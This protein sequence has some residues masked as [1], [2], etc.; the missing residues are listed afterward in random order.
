M[1]ARRNARGAFSNANTLNFVA[2]QR[3]AA[4]RSLPASIRTSPSAGRTTRPLRAAREA[5]STSASIFDLTR[6]AATQGLINSSSTSATIVDAGK[7]SSRRRPEQQRP[8]AALVASV[9]RAAAGTVMLAG[10][11]TYR[12]T[13][14]FSAV[15]GIDING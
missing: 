4:R 15:A 9:L 14:P 12:S 1:S 5:A 6:L 3:C 7:S 13:M 10:V 2:T 11:F 8:A